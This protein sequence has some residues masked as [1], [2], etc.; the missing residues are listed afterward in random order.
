M[1][2]LTK[3]YQ[4]IFNSKT[5]KEEYGLNVLT[6]DFYEWI[7]IQTE[8]IN[9]DVINRC[10]N[11]EIHTLQEWA[12]ITGCPVAVEEG[13]TLCGWHV[14]KPKRAQHIWLHMLGSFF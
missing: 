3:K 7:E 5:L 11:G 9:K 6:K 13:C 10:E 8:R 2:S 1:K 4:G 14:T 12:N